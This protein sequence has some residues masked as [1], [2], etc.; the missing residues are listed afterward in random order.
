MKNN[1]NIRTKGE[2][3]TERTRKVEGECNS[4]EEKMPKR[5]TMNRKEGPYG[6]GGG[7]GDVEYKT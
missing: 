1:A 3:E 6:G 2:G 7:G 5:R 4:Q